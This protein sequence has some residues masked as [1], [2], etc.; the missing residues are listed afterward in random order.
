M[1]NPYAAIRQLER[2]LEHAQLARV[3][4]EDESRLYH[5]QLVAARESESQARKDWMDLIAKLPLFQP[6][7][8]RQPLP[9]PMRR[10]IQH[11]ADIEKI[12][13]ADYERD[14]G[15]N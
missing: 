13:M 6:P 10:P 2:E 7:P 15:I 9:A 11:A 14:L 12:K 3:K 4:A 5:A 8:E 1:L